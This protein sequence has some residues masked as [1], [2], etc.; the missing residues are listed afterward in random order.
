MTASSAAKGLSLPE[1]KAYD[2][3]HG[4]ANGVRG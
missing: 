2:G 1:L 3:V 4:A